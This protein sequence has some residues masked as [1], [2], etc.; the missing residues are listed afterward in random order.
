MKRI[1]ICLFAVLAALILSSCS[2]KPPELSRDFA[3]EMTAKSPDA[4]YTGLVTCS[5]GS[6]T[7]SLTSPPEV[8]GISYTLSDTKLRASLD[9]LTC[10]TSADSLSPGSLPALIC[11]AMQGLD[12]AAYVSSENR[13]DIYTVDTADGA[14]T[15]TAENGLPISVTADNSPYSVSLDTSQLP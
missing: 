2:A 10:I 5:V 4:E 11:A 12:T 14:V 1:S 3:C 8:A 9:G 15:V 6:V 7:L 13:R